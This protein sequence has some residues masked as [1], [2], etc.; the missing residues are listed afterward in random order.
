M[1]RL[2]VITGGSRGIGFA[3]A[4]LLLE[5][6]HDVVI[7]G[8]T[9]ESLDR[10]CEELAGLGTISGLA[11]DS[12][13]AASTQRALEPLGADIL[14][15]N[16]GTG[17]SG[18]AQSTSL[19]E[20]EM[21]LRTNLTSAFAAMK[22]ALPAMLDRGWGR[23]VSVGSMASHQPIR[24]GAAYTASKHALLGLTR[25]VAEDTRGTG[26]T[27]N[28]VAPAF[29]RTDMTVANAQRIAEARGSSLAEAEQQLGTMSN[30]GRLIEPEE[31][32]EQI[33]ALTTEDLTTT[34]TSVPM[35]FEL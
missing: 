12:A 14:V 32:A 3:T 1:S 9:R 24:Y 15:C 20:W 21:V 13:D 5:L 33:V 26:V 27:A 25:A 16:V 29:V 7:T 8:R 17:F 34:G 23:I 19:D 6:G 11:L 35:G 2:A 28:L 30:L 22:A 18:T 4:R 10:A 31:V